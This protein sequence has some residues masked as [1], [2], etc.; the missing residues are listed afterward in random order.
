MDYYP[1]LLRLDGRPCLVVGGGTVATQKVRSLL[2]ARARVTVVA[3]RLSA[4]LR[5]L[6]ATGVIVSRE[7]PFAAGDTH[8]CALVYAATSDETV[9]RAV[10]DEGEAARVLVN[11]VD[12]PRLCRFIAPA[13][14]RRGDL[15]V[16][17]STGG[18]SPALA[19]RLRRDLETAL[20][21]EYAVALRLLGRL[22]EALRARALPPPERQRILRTMVDSALLELVRDGNSAAIDRL[23][24]DTIGAPC[25]LAGL[26]VTLGPA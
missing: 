24:T 3:P 1:I 18:A 15:T 19:S 10:F 21:M 5:A 26:G 4:A 8:G 6:A 13:V 12:R 25:S 9:N 23:L 2:E 14:V 20:G 16:A 17:I 7:R 11:V 22:R